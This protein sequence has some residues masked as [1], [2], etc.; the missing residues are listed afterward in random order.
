MRLRPFSKSQTRS[1]LLVRLALFFALVTSAVGYPGHGV[2]RYTRHHLKITGSRVSTSELYRIGSAVEPAE[3]QKEQHSVRVAS[4]QVIWTLRWPAR[5]NVKDGPP[6][7]LRARQEDEDK[8]E[9][10]KQRPRPGGGLW[11]AFE[12][13]DQTGSPP[14]KER[15]EWAAVEGVFLTAG[16]VLGIILACACIT[17]L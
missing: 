3:A 10:S 2:G 14:V 5:L 9:Q 4:R 1:S 16:L 6:K 8:T 15:H 11:V 17:I 7:L 12:R 13:L